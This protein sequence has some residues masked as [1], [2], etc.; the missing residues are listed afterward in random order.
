[1]KQ[2]ITAKLKLYATPE[3]FSAFR[4]TQLAYRDAL[5]AVSRYAYAHG[6]MSNQRRLQEGT[7]DDIRALYGLPAQMACNVPRQVGATYKGLWT[8]ARKHAEM[9]RAGI[10]RKRYKGLD[11]PPTYVSPTLTYN[12]QRDYTLKARQ[13]VSIL[14][15]CG[16]VIVPYSGY[17]KHLALIRSGA[18][19]G[20]AKLWYDQPHKQFYLLVSLEIELADPTFEQS[21]SLVGVDVGIRYLAVTS[22]STG[23]PAFFAGKQTKHRAN[24]YARLR[25]RLQQKGTRGSK[26]KLR[27]IEQRERR[28]K[29]QVN[30]Q[31]A[32]QIVAAH[33]Q[34]MIG[35]EELT[36]IRER[37]KARK[38]KKGGKGTDPA[39]P[40]MRRAN[41]VHA[42]WSFA[43]LHALIAY[44]AA[45]AGSLAIKVDAN[46]TSKACPKCGF[47][48]E[49]NRPH[50]G[51]V[52]HCG[53]CHYQLHADLVGARNIVMR[54][55][56]FRQV[57]SQTGQLSVAPDVS[58][59]EAKALRLQRY[60]ELRWS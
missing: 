30:H 49:D 59:K 37:T 24:H 60:K 33:P 52:F 17:T 4:A 51:L 36:D 1:M 31:I 38:R 2:L 12:N 22:T 29:L 50:K 53:N 13:R 47:T 27:R 55:L 25:K 54:T 58:D 16:R 9:R 6:K 20:A 39:T 23:D 40:K 35:L 3:Q 46:Y 18:S 32:K 10:S 43:E 41:R 56:W 28:L 48:H 8:R 42:Q 57:W 5:N 14:T 21:T 44:K 19:L 7:Y 15:L 45:L 26:K 34:A 11:Q